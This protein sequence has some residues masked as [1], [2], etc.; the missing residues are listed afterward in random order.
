M[1]LSAIQTTT[2]PGAIL[3]LGLVF[4][5]V[6]V[7]GFLMA[8]FVEFRKMKAAAGQEEA[9]RQ[10]VRRYEQ[11]GENT[12]DAQQRV[13]ADISEVRSRMASIEQILRTV[14]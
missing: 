5:A 7:L 12:L 4:L 2:W 11:L 14:E 9:L 10:L 3:T 6:A 1:S 13:A 8:T